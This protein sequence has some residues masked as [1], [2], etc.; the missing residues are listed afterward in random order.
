[1]RKSGSKFTKYLSLTKPCLTLVNLSPVLTYD[2]LQF[3]HYAQCSY[4]PDFEPVPDYDMQRPLSPDS[5]NL[6]DYEA[7]LRRVLPGFV[8]NALEAAVNNEPTA[9][10]NTNTTANGRYY[11]R[12]AEPSLHELS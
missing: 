7:Y 11:A 5:V 3:L 6:A 2:F 4:S 9:N 12:S 1:M 10:R 8:R